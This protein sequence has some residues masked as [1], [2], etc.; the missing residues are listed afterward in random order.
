MFLAL[1]IEV[2]M[3]KVIDCAEFEATSVVEVSAEDAQ[4][5]TWKGILRKE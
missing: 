5:V 1:A 3:A 4:N 2:S